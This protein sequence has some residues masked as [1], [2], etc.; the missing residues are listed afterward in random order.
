MRFLRLALVLLACAAF[1][2][3]ARAQEVVKITSIGPGSVS[4]A[5]KIAGTV[6]LKVATKCDSV[7][8]YAFTDGSKK[9]KDGVKLAVGTDGK[10]DSV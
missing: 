2:S 6:D 8:V 4:K 10:W 1:T 7:L 9:P 5:V 3:E